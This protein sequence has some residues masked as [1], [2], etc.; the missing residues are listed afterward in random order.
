[1]NKWFRQSNAL[2]KRATG[3]FCLFFAMIFPFTAAGMSPEKTKDIRKLLIVSGIHEQ[4]DYMKRDLLNIFSTEVG[5]RFPNIPDGFWE[6]F[7]VSV[8]GKSDM[9]SLYDTVVP[10]YDKHMDHETIKKLIQMFDNPFWEEWKTKM[11]IISNEAGRAGGAW[12]QVMSGS[13]NIRKRVEFLVEKYDLET[14][15]QK[16][17]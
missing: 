2:R 14:L 1:M 8:V 9:E 7:N 11:P 15:N 6:E 17:R 10:V 16:Q 4:L 13:E 3:M 12:I 5:T